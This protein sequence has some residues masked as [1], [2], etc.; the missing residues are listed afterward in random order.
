MAIDDS[1]LQAQ[2]RS[3]LNEIAFAPFKHCLPLSPEFEEIP[4]RPGIYAVRHQNGG[5]ALYR[6]KRKACEVALRAGTRHSYGRGWINMMIRTLGLRS[7]L[8]LTGE[9]PDYY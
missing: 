5:I 2:A 8:S 7:G 6:V 4:A 1:A 9:I 3:I